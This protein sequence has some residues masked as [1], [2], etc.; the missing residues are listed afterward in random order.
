MGQQLRVFRAETLDAAYRQ[1]RQELG[2]EAVVVNAVERSGSGVRGLL[3]KRVAEVTAALTVPDPP[4]AA[5][6][7]TPLER[8]YLSQAGNAAPA[9]GSDAAVK[10]TVEYFQQ[11]VTQAQQRMARANAPERTAAPAR[12]APV[13]DRQAEAL[14]REILTI[15]EMVQV[16]MAER[17]CAGV[18]DDFV[19]HY[20]RLVELGVTRKLAAQLVLDTIAGADARS[21]RD[22]RVFKER[23]KL[24]IRRGIQVTGGIALHAGQCRVAA[25]VGATGVGKTT[26][27]AK[28][29][30]HYAVR[31]R[32]RVALI[33][34][35]TYRVAAPDQL[36]VYANI[37][38]LPLHIA[39]DARDYTAALRKVSGHDLV[40][41]DT[42]GGSQYNTEQID[43]LR[44]V[45][46]AAPP[47]EVILV[48]AANAQLEEQQTVL[49]NFARLA[50]TSLMISKIDETRRY[51]T[52]LSV[53]AEAGLP[54]GYFSTG[55]SVPDDIALAQPGM[56]ANWVVEGEDRR[57]RSSA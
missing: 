35:D 23:L 9:V 11:I 37:I 47:D 43:E 42:A 5:R 17:P 8:K 24:Q 56:V 57:G 2:E 50:P 39:N 4:P 48:V 29:A 20:Y 38:G 13:V 33:T 14:R 30:A 53:A 49:A 19:P 52:V 1:M 3:G 27:L 22:P 6:K 54:L 28:I 18:P 32:A 26:N 46:Q 41:V 21:L 55:Q 15:R 7:P 36:R 44:G 51:G 40:L 10:D 16:L 31:E 34:T 25:L 45:F 12:K